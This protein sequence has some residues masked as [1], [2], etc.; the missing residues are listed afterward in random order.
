[1][2]DAS[3]KPHCLRLWVLAACTLVAST[4][5]AAPLDDALNRPAALTR[6]PQH[7][8]LLAAAAAGERW[9]AVGERGVIVWSDDHGQNWQQA[10]VPVSTTLTAVTFVDTQHGWAAGHAGVV[11]RSVDGGM[12]WTRV[13]DGNLLAR[14]LLDEAEAMGDTRA[15]GEANALLADGADKPWLDILALD[16]QRLLVVGAYGLAMFSDD[17]GEHWHSWH[18]RLPNPQQL[19]LYA[20]RRTGTAW[21]LAG[22]QG[23]ALY[24]ND[25]GRSFERLHPPYPG[26]FFAA[27][28]LD[29]HDMILAGL[30][31][32]V[33]RS[34]DGGQSWQSLPLPAP[35]SVTATAQDGRG[36]VLA[37]NQAGEVLRLQSDTWMKLN[38]SPLPPL[39]GLLA[40]P[41]AS[42]LVVGMQGAH[43]L[44]E[45]GR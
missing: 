1:L 39:A 25:D 13:L 33:L 45:G 18:A 10:E 27:E 3:M 17:G 38:Q 44:P 15:I 20:A 24:S 31:G 36:Q 43:V 29:E 23:L 9:V 11:L 34:R 8:V 26:S 28:L 37:V 5:A 7:S 6:A 41:G 4:A 42:W 2:N 14:Q 19:H 32:N 30:R 40:R 12:R 16:A 21:L 22:E 35:V